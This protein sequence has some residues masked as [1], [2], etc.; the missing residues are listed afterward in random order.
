M[1]EQGM[2]ITIF[3]VREADRVVHDR[4]Y[5]LEAVRSLLGQSHRQLGEAHIEID[6]L[7][8]QKR[9]PRPVSTAP[10]NVSIESFRLKK[11][12]IRMIMACEIRNITQNGKAM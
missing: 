4:Q 11:C 6:N 2:S 5:E 7:R 10:L 9:N 3:E 1:I 12:E 8:R